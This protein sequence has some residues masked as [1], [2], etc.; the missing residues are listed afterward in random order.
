MY[1]SILE[2]PQAVE[3]DLFSV[4]RTSHYRF[5]SL[6]AFAPASCSVA[7]ILKGD[8]LAAWDVSVTLAKWK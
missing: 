2:S 1:H 6:A 3:F 7:K 4:G 8:L 5:L